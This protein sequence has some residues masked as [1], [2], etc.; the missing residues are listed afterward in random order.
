MVPMARSKVI[1]LIC[2]RFG[3]CKSSNVA[4]GSGPLSG[5]RSGFK[6]Y[7]FFFLVGLEGLGR[8]V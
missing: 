5:Q 4:R 1:S 6:A 3:I 2:C 8:E 7:F